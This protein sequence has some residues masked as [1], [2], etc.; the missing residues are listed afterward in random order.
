MDWSEL[1]SFMDLAKRYPLLT[2]EEECSLSGI[3]TDGLK[4]AR[5]LRTKDLSPEQRTA[6]GLRVFAGEKARERFLNSNLRLVVSIA[7]KYKHDT[8]SLSDL[9]QEG[10]IGLMRA[11]EKFDP[12]RGFKFSTYASWW[13]RQAMTRALH[14][15]D[16]IRV[17]V[18]RVET[19]NQVRRAENAAGMSNEGR[20]PDEVIAERTGLTTREVSRSRTLPYIG[21]SLDDPFGE[22]DARVGDNLRDEDAQ[23][24]EVAAILTDIQ[25]KFDQLFVDFTERDKLIFQMRFGDDG[26]SLEEIG[27][28]VGLTR[29]RVRQI[30]E[31]H[32]KSLRERARSLGMVG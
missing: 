2:R 26:A 23:D 31:R 21:A 8:Y 1:T 22:G 25:G 7:K 11:L 24:A 19:R 15:A 5:D 4:A 13:I 14:Q 20:V 3:F 27:N 12:D 17:P 32:K 18:Y 6:L 9:V 16:M 29:E 30:I 28:V 10:N